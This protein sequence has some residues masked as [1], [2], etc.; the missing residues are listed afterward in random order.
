MTK[1]EIKDVIREAK[2]WLK[3][4]NSEEEHDNDF[5]IVLKDDAATIIT[6]LIKV[7]KTLQTKSKWKE[8]K[9]SH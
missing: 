5:A 8:K 3:D 7:I 2:Q 9:V 1:K 6:S 4:Y